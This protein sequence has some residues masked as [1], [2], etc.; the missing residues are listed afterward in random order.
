M[1]EFQLS[2]HDDGILT[3]NLSRTRLGVQRS[4]VWFM[5][6]LHPIVHSHTD[7]D[8]FRFLRLDNV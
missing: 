6:A 7:A 2:S 1:L 4:Y 3:N 5:L 8:Q